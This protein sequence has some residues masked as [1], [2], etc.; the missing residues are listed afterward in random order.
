MQHTDY[1]I[2]DFESLTSQLDFPQQSPTSIN[3]NLVR[4]KLQP[5]AVRLTR[6]RIGSG[7]IQV[8][9]PIRI[10]DPDF[11]WIQIRGKNK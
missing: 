5:L 10:R 11:P 4:K 2:L 9:L 7:R 8:F 6:I 3:E 1:T